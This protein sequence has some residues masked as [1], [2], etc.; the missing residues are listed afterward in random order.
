MKDGHVKLKRYYEEGADPDDYYDLTEYEI[1]FDSITGE[2]KV[3]LSCAECGKE[4]GWYCYKPGTFYY[5]WN[6]LVVEGVV[7]NDCYECDPYQYEEGGICG[8]ACSC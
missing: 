2:Y 6:D 4:I 5:L 7:C 3:K 8:T 1:Y